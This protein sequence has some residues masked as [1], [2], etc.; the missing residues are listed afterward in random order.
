MGDLP[1]PRSSAASVTIENVGTYL[2]GGY[3][4]SIRNTSD[5]LAARSTKW[6]GGP[7]IPVDMNF[8][9]AVSISQLSFLIIHGNN[10]REYQVDILDPTS[11]SG[12]QSASK[13]PQLQTYRGRQPGCGKIGDQVVIGGGRD[14]SYQFLRSTEVLDLS[15]RTIVYAGDLN[16]PRAY[17]HM[18]TITVNGEQIMFAF[19]GAD[20][21]WTTQNSVEQ[22]D[23]KNNT[24]T[25]TTSMEES[26][27]QF[28]AVAV[29]RE[30][31]CAT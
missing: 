28:G 23:P 6:T 3:P 16:S 19:G 15:T 27:Y 29:A 21:N 24:W 5:F 25:L 18:A 4:R 2:I 9:C 12:W 1:Q 7:A 11:S 20:E 8:P 13:Y 17:F 10:I 22:F 14:S 31:A 30:H 26:R